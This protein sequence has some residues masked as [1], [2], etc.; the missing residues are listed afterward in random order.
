M[1]TIKISAKSE[2]KSRTQ[3]HKHT[4]LTPLERK[5]QRKGQNNI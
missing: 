5:V 4:D 1:D 3:P 2:N